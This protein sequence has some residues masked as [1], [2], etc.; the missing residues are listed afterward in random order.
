MG[1]D[2]MPRDQPTTLLVLVPTQGQ[3][4]QIPVQWDGSATPQDQPPSLRVLVPTQGM[5]CRLGL[6]QEMPKLEQPARFTSKKQTINSQQARQKLELA[7]LVISSPDNNQYQQAPR[8]Q[9]QAFEREE[10]LSEH[11]HG[12]QAGLQRPQQRQQCQ[13]QQPQQSLLM[14][15]QSPQQLPFAIHE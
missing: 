15:Q 1:A 10:R 5:Q 4:N 8:P 3:V 2:S 12:L 6:Q 14:P 9:D 11:H 13:R 7:Q